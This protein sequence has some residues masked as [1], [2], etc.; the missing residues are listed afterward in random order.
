V[1]LSRTEREAVVPEAVA[2]HRVVTGVEGCQEQHDEDD[3]DPAHRVTRLVACDDD[4]RSGVYQRE[5]QSRRDVKDRQLVNE[6][7]QCH[8]DTEQHK[9]EGAEGV[10]RRR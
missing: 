5:S 10:R 8:G 1:S 2:K 3:Q 7:G 6:N 4:T 9:H